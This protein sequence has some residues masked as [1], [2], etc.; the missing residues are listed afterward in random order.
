L[1]VY[2]DDNYI[3]S[4]CYILNV[5]NSPPNSPTIDGPIRG[6]IVVE[7]EYTFNATDPDDDPVMYIIEW[8]N[9]NTEWTEYVDSDK[10]IKLNH[11]WYDKGIYTIKAKARDCYNEE[12]DWTYLEV[13]MSHSYNNPVGWL[14]SWLDRFPLLQRLLEVL[15]R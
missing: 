5:G 8:T 15:T 14:N 6:K 9:N 11:T 10:E 13:T 3:D 7:H 12:S 1:L 4:Q 2:D